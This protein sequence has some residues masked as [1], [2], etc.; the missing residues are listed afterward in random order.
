M[1]YHAT[2]IFL[3]SIGFSLLAHQ[4]FKLAQSSGEIEQTG[5]DALLLAIKKSATNQ[6]L[7]EAL[8]KAISAGQKLKFLF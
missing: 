7:L 2:L 4:R 5:T 8:P 3:L 6:E 1:Y